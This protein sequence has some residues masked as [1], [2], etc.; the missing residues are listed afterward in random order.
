MD[1]VGCDLGPRGKVP[2]VQR[3]AQRG[4]GGITEGSVEEGTALGDVGVGGD[5]E[6]RA[7]T[8]EISGSV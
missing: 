4:Q 1:E 6:G 8:D 2:R 5:A 3:F 7:A